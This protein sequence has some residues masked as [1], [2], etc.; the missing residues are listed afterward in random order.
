MPQ[1]SR[2]RTVLD[3]AIERKVLRRAEGRKTVRSGMPFS[4]EAGVEKDFAGC[5]G[6]GEMRSSLGGRTGTDEDGEWYGRADGGISRAILDG[7]AGGRGSFG[8]REGTNGV[9]GG[10][11]GTL[12]CIGEWELF[13]T[14]G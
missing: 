2:L 12:N 6:W 5:K 8:G 14:V 9:N 3:L 1:V 4:R 7:R 11:D 13:G 10:N